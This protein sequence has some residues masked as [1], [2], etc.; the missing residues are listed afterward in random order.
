M[1]HGTVQDSDDL[2]DTS[3][4]PEQNHVSFLCRDLTT[5]KE[6]VA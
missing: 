4:D 3:F 1:V 2:Q 6:I 5:G